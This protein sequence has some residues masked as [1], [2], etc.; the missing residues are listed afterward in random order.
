MTQEV[1]FMQQIKQQKLWYKKQE[2]HYIK[3]T[4]FL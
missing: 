4:M 3:K 1:F 2:A